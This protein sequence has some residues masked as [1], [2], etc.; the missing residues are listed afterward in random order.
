[1]DKLTNEMIV[2]LANDLGLEPAP[3]KIPNINKETSNTL[4]LVTD[5]YHDYN[6]SAT[7]YPDG[8][9]IM[10]AIQRRYSRNT[11][12]NPFTLTTG[13]TWLSI[14]TA[15]LY[16]SNTHYQVE[17]YKVTLWYLAVPMFHRGLS[18]F[19]SLSMTLGAL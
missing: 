16:I 13:Q 19:N 15:L 9:A 12:A 6:L 5:P 7:G 3:L 1:M 18:T 4:M 17:P 8:S 11:I 14:Y 2:A 10:S